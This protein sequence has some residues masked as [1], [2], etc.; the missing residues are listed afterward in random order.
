MLLIYNSVSIQLCAF[1]Q[2]QIRTP[3]DLMRFKVFFTFNDFRHL[4]ENVQREMPIQSVRKFILSHTVEF[5]GIIKYVAHICYLWRI[6]L[7]N[8]LIEMQCQF[9]HAAH[10]CNIRGIPL[11]YR[12][13]EG[14]CAKE[15]MVL[16]SRRLWYEVKMCIIR[17]F[18]RSYAQYRAFFGFTNVKSIIKPYY[19]LHINQLSH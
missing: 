1:L 9:K 15:H 18:V 14:K 12:L 19:L 2:L 17:W 5:S 7:V 13:I 3:P 4:K 11:S 8:R 16:V 10:I 6:P